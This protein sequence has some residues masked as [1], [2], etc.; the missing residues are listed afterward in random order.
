MS[1]DIKKLTDFG[2]IGDSFKNPGAAS[3]PIQTPSSDDLTTLFTDAKTVLMNAVQT[4][5]S[6]A[7]A[8]T[9]GASFMENAPQIVGLAV[10]ILGIILYIQIQVGNEQASSRNDNK[11]A[12]SI[13][14]SIDLE[15]PSSKI[16]KKVT[17]ELFTPQAASRSSPDASVPNPHD[18]PGLATRSMKGGTVSASTM[19]NNIED[20]IVHAV[21]TIIPNAPSA[22]T[23][24]RLEQKSATCKSTDAFC[25]QNHADIEKVCGD[26]KSQGTCSEKCCC[27]WVKF[28][29]EGN[30]KGGSAGKSV[31]HSVGISPDGK[32]VAGDVKGPE[33][34]FNRDIDYYYYMGECMK[35]V[36]KPKGT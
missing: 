14:D 22:Q 10:F 19:G 6:G 4:L 33:L 17:L 24:E 1:F 34:T 28:S 35:G 32:C 16:S 23:R 2:N 27:G 9:L 5:V 21:S 18:P 25:K 29:N 13:A 8:S 7:T 31:L 12:S 36:C 15:K 11:Y 3:S 30:N 26:I 20:A